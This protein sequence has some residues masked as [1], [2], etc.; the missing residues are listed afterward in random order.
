MTFQGEILHG[1]NPEDWETLR[2]VRSTLVVYSVSGYEDFYEKNL[3]HWDK[4]EEQACKLYAIM[5]PEDPDLT[6]QQVFEHGKR[7]YAKANRILRN[8]GLQ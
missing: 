6:S 5:Y 3:R 4:D 2:D 7:A 1:T 8:M